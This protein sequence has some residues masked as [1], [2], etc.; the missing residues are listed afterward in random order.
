VTVLRGETQGRRERRRAAAPAAVGLTLMPLSQPY[1]FGRHALSGPASQSA[2]I[3]AGRL[4]VA[5]GKGDRDAGSSSSCSDGLLRAEG[6]S[7]RDRGRVVGFDGRAF[8]DP[9]F[10]PLRT[11]RSRWAASASACRTGERADGR[12]PGGQ[13]WSAEGGEEVAP[14]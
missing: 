13:F 4:V 6:D 9:V 7:K 3:W 11:R 12:R 8:G 2:R 10:V 5:G 1:R 14:A